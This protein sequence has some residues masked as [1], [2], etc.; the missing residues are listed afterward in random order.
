MLEAFEGLHS[1]D[2]CLLGFDHCGEENPCPLHNHWKVAKEEIKN[3]FAEK[4]LAELIGLEDQI[5]QNI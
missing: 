3:I 2:S 5:L 1:I 4:T